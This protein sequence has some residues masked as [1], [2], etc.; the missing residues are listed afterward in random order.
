M[1]IPKDAIVAELREY[2]IQPKGVFHVGAHEC[3]ELA[4]YNDY[5]GLAA[6]QV[7]WIDAIPEK[8]EAARQRGVPN[9]FE[10]VVWSASGVPKTFNVSNNIQ[11]SSLLPFKTHA[12]E[13]PNV[14]F[15]G[16]REVVTTTVDDFF[17]TQGLNPEPLDF[18][19]LDIQGVELEALK[20]A[21]AAL[22]SVKAVYAEVNTAELYEGCG[23]AWDIEDFLGGLGFEK[24]RTHMTRH[25]WGDALFVRPS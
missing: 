3:E 5:L 17:S 2:G 20:G 9:V 25:G 12:V 21:T 7:V 4:F 22:K 8:V 14:Y 16:T 23:M 24:V 19:N 15:T 10:A 18:W 11:S 13:H 6:E 1:L